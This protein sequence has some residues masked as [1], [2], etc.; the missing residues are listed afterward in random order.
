[1]KRAGAHLHVVGL[2]D[3]AA[4][5]RPEALE[6]ENQ[7]L[8]ARWR[9][10]RGGRVDVSGRHDVGILPRSLLVRRNIEAPPGRIKRT[11]PLRRRPR[12]VSV[13]PLVG[14]STAARPLGVGLG[15]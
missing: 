4:L 14:L 7:L 3:G 11:A 12:E 15:G 10:R 6:R 2:E 13:A 5:L 8:K 9:R 1:M